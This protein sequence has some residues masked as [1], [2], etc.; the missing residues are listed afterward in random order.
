MPEV[1]VGNKAPEFTL[2]DT[3]LKQRKLSEFLGKKLVLAFFPGAFTSV[4]TKELCT[5]RD[6]MVRLNE[7]QAQVIQLQQ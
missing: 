4:C 2:F 3:N 7:L 6:S 1:V 5:F